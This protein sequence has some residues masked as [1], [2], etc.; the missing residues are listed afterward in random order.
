[1]ALKRAVGVIR[2]RSNLLGASVFG[3]S[4]GSLRDGVLGQLSW[5]DETDSS[6]H[7]SA[8]DG[9]SFIVV[10]QTGSLGSDPLKDIINEAV[11]DA[12]GFAGNT[13][14]RVNLFQH[15]VD[16]DAIAF[17]PLPLLFLVPSTGGF[18]LSCFLGSFAANLWWHDDCS[19]QRLM[20]DG[21]RRPYIL[22]TVCK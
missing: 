21:G 3:H 18:R 17:L 22:S 20:Q 8:G 7:L 6:L 12:H 9:G 14:V 19:S 2:S 11:H 13:G 15:F 4:L 16:V 1:M 5:Q 10:S